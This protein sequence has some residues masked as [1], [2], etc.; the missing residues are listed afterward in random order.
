MMMIIELLDKCCG[1]R[2]KVLN[3]FLR[4]IG[5]TFNVMNTLLQLYR[6]ILG[7]VVQ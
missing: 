3:E 4:G 7:V 6:S 2:G 5:D 1:I